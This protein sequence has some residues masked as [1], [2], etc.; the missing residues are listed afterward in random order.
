MNKIEDQKTELIVSA[1]M[2]ARE[3]ADYIGVGV[4]D[5]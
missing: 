4:K 2:T 1:N 5:Y 3:V